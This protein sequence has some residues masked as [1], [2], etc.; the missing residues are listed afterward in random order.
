MVSQKPISAWALAPPSNCSFSVGVER[1]S[2][3]R[4]SN[5]NRKW[6]AK[7]AYCFHLHL[8][9]MPALS[10]LAPFY[11]SLLTWP[12]ARPKQ[13]YMSVDFFPKPNGL[14]MEQNT[15]T[16]E[17][18]AWVHSRQN[19]NV[20]SLVSSARFTPNFEHAY[21]VAL[22]MNIW[23]FANVCWVIYTAKRR[24]NEHR[25]STCHHNYMYYVA[26]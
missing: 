6:S 4:I 22:Q 14:E 7:K 18:R 13:N 3:P 19:V 23:H 2:A 26:Q 5:A 10:F 1:A 25:A 15:S 21:T 9:V 20:F 17:G 11:P 8:R 24:K 12:F 16:G